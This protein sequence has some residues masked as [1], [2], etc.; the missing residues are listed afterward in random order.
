MRNSCRVASILLLLASASHA[1]QTSYQGKWTGLATAGNGSQIRVDLT[2]TNAG[3]TLR[4]S[5]SMNYVTIDQ[6][7]DR[8]IPVTVES[9]TESEMTIAIMGAKIL[10]G[11]IDETAT[12]KLIDAKTL[13]GTLKDG[14][15]VKLTRK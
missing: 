1:Q 13:Q 4:T 2:I 3:G 12:L 14:R 6:C 8:D 5:P 9:Q 10:K 7:H 15:T 11:C